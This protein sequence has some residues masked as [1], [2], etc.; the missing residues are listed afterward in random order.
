M[1]VSWLCRPYFYAAAVPSA[2]LAYAAAAVAYSQPA[3][4]GSKVME[5][6]VARVGDFTGSNQ[7]K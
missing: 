4:R 5:Q 7:A 2:S 6:S 1:F 3:V